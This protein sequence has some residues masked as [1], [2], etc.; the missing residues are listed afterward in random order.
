[1]IEFPTGGASSGQTLAADSILRLTP[2]DILL[3]KNIRPDIVENINDSAFFDNSIYAMMLSLG[4]EETTTTT[5]NYHYQTGSY[6]APATVASTSGATADEITL[7]YATSSVAGSSGSYVSPGMVGDVV[8]IDQRYTAVVT[9]KAASVSNNATHSITIS[10]G[11]DTSFALNDTSVVTAGSILSF[12]FSAQVSGQEFPDGIAISDTRFKTSLHYMMTSTSEV[13]SDLANQQT[14]IKLPNYAG[15]DYYIERETVALTVRHSVKKAGAMLIANGASYS[16]TV[17]GVSKSY[18]T[19]TGLY[20]TAAQYG[21][22]TAITPGLMDLD[23]IYNMAQRAR[24]GQQGDELM[25]FIGSA[26]KREWDAIFR[27]QFQNGAVVY[28]DPT[29][30]TFSVKNNGQSL[31]RLSDEQAKEHSIALGFKAV[32][33]LNITIHTKVPTEFDHPTIFNMPGLE[34]GYYQNSIL[35]TTSGKTVSMNGNTLQGVSFGIKSRLGVVG[36]GFGAPRQKVRLVNQTPANFGSER[37]KRTFIEE[38]G[39]TTYNANKLQLIT[40]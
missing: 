8:L 17:D 32:T 7:V 18:P 30:K 28:A 12:P 23:D 6:F 29:Y 3:M 14:Y 2:D 35:T 25:T 27:T 9:A 11:S 15:T 5:E 39:L 34:N 31:S 16:T 22:T 37:F 36:E 4:M 33:L 13:L 19:T 38:F 40:L 1:M 20:P 26:R 24:S 10:R 21:S